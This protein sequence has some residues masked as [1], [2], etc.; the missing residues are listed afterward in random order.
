MKAQWIDIWIDIMFADRWHRKFKYT[1][2]T[3]FNTWAADLVAY[4][5]EKF[6]YLVERKEFDLWF[7]LPNVKEPVRLVVRPKKTK[8]H[9]GRKTGNHTNCCAH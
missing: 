8:V 4:T 1:I 6:P 2:D 7:N 9:H 5:L 3:I